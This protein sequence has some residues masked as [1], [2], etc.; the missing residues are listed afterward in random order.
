MAEMTAVVWAVR[1]A[2]L[3]AAHLVVDSAVRSADWTVVMKVSE[4]DL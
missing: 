4:L 3:W 2:A 1:K